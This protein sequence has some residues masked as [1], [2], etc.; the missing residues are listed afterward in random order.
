VNAKMIHFYCLSCG[1]LSDQY[2]TPP[3]TKPTKTSVT[4]ST[5]T[6]TTSITTAPK[7]T[8]TGPITPPTTPTKTA[9]IGTTSITTAA[10]STTTTQT[11][12][13]GCNVRS[14]KINISIVLLVIF[15]NK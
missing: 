7:L 5:T 10:K 15:H 4:K 9:V 1:I 6:D 2:T 13:M 11:I 12:S 8:A 14:M 3:A